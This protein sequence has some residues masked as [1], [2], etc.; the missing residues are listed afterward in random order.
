[1]SSLCIADSLLHRGLCEVEELTKALTSSTA[2]GVSRRQAIADMMSPHAESPAES[3]ARFYLY[4]WK[5]PRPQEQKELRVG[6]RLYRPDFVW[7]EYGLILEVDGEVK[8]SGEFGD[9]QKVIRDELRRQRELERAGW[10]VV[11]VRWKELVN[12]PETL[13][14]AL[15]DEMNRG[16]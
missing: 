5:L 12:S 9:P 3:I 14:C 16:R 8:Y 10:R 1:M 4:L 6:G 13:R 7:E 2:P 15:L 11:R